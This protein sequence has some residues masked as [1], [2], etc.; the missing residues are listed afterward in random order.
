MPHKDLEEVRN[1]WHEF[2][3]TVE[4]ESVTEGYYA[5]EQIADWWL[6]EMKA[7]EEKL[8][9]EIGG[10]KWEPN[11]DYSAFSKAQMVRRHNDDLTALLGSK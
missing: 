1:K 7:R 10:R 4:A 9:E 2:S 6:A 8:R 5:H 3:K 11:G